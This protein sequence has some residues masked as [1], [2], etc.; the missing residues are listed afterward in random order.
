MNRGGTYANAQEVRTC[1]F[2]LANLEFT[3]RIRQFAQRDDFRQICRVTA[4]QRD[5]QS[6]IE[7]VVRIMVHTHIDFTRG[8]D[9]QEFLDQAALK[10]LIE[11]NPDEV[12]ETM[13]WSVET[14]FSL[15]RLCTR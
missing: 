9:V 8:L 11:Y 14:L 7:Y 4:E 15:K 3:Q 6:D 12:L 5:T 1:S 10:I 13:G 2:V